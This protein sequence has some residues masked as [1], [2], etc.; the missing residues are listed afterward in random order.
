MSQPELNRY[1]VSLTK[2]ARQSHDR[3]SLAADLKA[4]QGVE[5]VEMAYSGKSA[6]V[7]ASRSRL[8][9]IRK[10]V[11]YASVTIDVDLELL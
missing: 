8:G 7:L 5:L 10:A 11:P 4:V 2:E 1:H 6:T 3:H 9:Q